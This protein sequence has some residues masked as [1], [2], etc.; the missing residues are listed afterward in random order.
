VEEVMMNLHRLVRWEP[1][2]PEELAEMRERYRDVLCGVA[3][4]LSTTDGGGAEPDEYTRAAAWLRSAKL[5]HAF[6][7][8]PGRRVVDAERWRA[9][10]LGAL[11]SGSRTAEA[12]LGDVRTAYRMLK[13]AA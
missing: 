6:E 2:Q 10:T 9:G 4:E 1:L 7:L 3:G 13:E 11:A 12:A 5:P 8:G